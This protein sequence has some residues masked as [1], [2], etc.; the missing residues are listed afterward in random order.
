[1]QQKNRALPP[2]PLPCLA[3][4]LAAQ[5]ALADIPATPVMTV[6]KFNGPMTVPYYRADGFSGPGSPAGTLTQGTSLIPCLVIRNGQPLT[7]SKGTPYVGFEIL[8]DP[9][10][11]TRADTER[12]KRTLAE[13]AR[14]K[15]QNHHCDSGVKNVID[16][17]QL[18]SLEKAPFFDPPRS[19]GGGGA[20]GTSDLDRIVRAFHAS[21]QC[22]QANR[23][24]TGRRGALRAPGTP[25]SAPT[26][27]WAPNRAGPRQASR[28][29]D[30]HRD[31]RGARG[32]RL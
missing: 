27:A 2:W 1:M 15:V 29:C 20:A 22:E 17:R 21:P 28:L 26:A 7:D 19:G 14:L 10:R 23:A 24:L 4:L 11:A 9:R 3:L 25:S 32:P 13:R 6:Y 5:A 31:L 8:V 30:A 18:Y 12:F 16:V